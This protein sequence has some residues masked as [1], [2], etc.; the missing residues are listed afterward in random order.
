M[1]THRTHASARTV[2]RPPLPAPDRLTINRRALAIALDNLTTTRANRHLHTFE[3]DRAL[4]SDTQVIAD[5]LAE[6]TDRNDY[7]ARLQALETRLRLGGVEKTT[8][9]KD[10]TKTVFTSG[11]A[12]LQEA[13]TIYDLLTT[14][15]LGTP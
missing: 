1:F 6:A 2:A 13:R 7:D 15:G 4:P 14:Y 5:W 11:Q 10:Q 3:V 9:Y 8:A 12:L